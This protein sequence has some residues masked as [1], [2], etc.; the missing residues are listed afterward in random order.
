[1]AVGANGLPDRCPV[2]LCANCSAR[3]FIPVMRCA[4]CGHGGHLHISG[5]CY[6]TGDR[7]KCTGFTATSTP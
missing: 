2:E 4:S 1:V 6:A 3:V 5:A 7:C